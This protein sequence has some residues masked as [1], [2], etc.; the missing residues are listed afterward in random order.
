MDAMV[1]VNV[2]GPQGIIASHDVVTGK[3]AAL[4]IKVPQHGHFNIE[5]IDE[6]T[7]HAPQVIMTKRVG[8]NLVLVFEGDDENG[9][10]VILEDYYQNED[11]HLIGE[12]ENGQYY[13][14][15]PTTG[16][17]A[18]YP[19][20]LADG[21]SSEQV[22]GGEGS[23]L[24]DP[25]AD[26][27]HFAWLPW[28]IFGGGALGMAGAAIASNSHGH[29]H[30][31]EA[32]EITIAIHPASD[33]DKD[34]RPEFSGSSSSPNATVEITLPDGS[35]VTTTTD[36]NG[37][38]A[39]ESPNS[40]PN[41][42]II[43]TVTDSE[44]NSGSASGN[45]HDNTAP[46]VPIIN[47]N[48]DDQLAGTAEPGSTITVTDPATGEATTT[49][50]DDKGNWSI[51]PNP[52][53]EGDS[54]VTV[55]A[56]DPAGNVSPPLVIERPDVTLPD[57]ITSGLV[58]DS[59]GLNDDVAPIIGTIADGGVTNDTRPTYSGK[60]T[61]DIDHVNI[62][63]NGKLVGS[64]VVDSDGNW[65]FT[66]KTSLAEGSTHE[67][68]A[69][70]VDRAGNEGPRISGT[71][72][73]GWSFTID[74][75]P[76]DNSSSGI[77]AGSIT[78]T[79]DREPVT[80][81]ITDGS[82]TNDTRPTYSGQAT[83]DIDH[84]NIYDGGTLLGSAAVDGDG[85]WR[86]TPDSD[87]AEGRHEFT[88]SAVDA[89]GNEG[90]QLS[91]TDDAGW[92][93]TLDATAPDNSTSGIVAGSITLTDDRE[94]VTGLITDGSATNDTRPTYSGQATADI[95][96]V[97]IY[98]GGT[99]LGSAAVDGDGHWRFTP[100]SDLAEGR[101]EFTV[102]AVDASGN[103]GP[104]LSGTDDAGWSF[105]LDAT[106]PDNST[107]G[108]V[109]GSITLTDDREPV[110]G[111]ITDGSATNDTRPTYSGQATADID[112][113]NIYDGGTLLGSAAVDGDG[114]WRFTPDSDLAEGRHE[115]T[116]SAV[117]ASG[118]EGP[119]LSGTDDAGWSFTLDAT[120]PDNSTSG[121]VAGSITLTDDREPVTGE[122]TDGSATNDTRPTY[123]GQATAD[124]DHVN[125]YD[126]GTLLGSAAVDGDGH[127]RFTPDSDLAE[128]RHEFT[129]SA[130]DASGNEG[131][132]LSGTDDAG[133]SF[134]LDATAPD[135]STSGIVAGSITLTDDREPVTGEITDGSATNDTR[136]TY[137]GQATADID[138]VNIYDGGTLLGSAAVDGDG[139]W[140]FTPDSDLAEGRHEF[141][142]SAV[143]ASGN[144]GPP[145]SGTDD[146]GWS[147][148]LDATAPD[149]STS[150][151][152]VGSITLT[153]DREPVT[154]EITDGSA[155]NDTR[156][157]YSGQATADIDHVN[158]YDGGT[159]LGSA[160]VDGDGH[161]RFTPDSDL[162]EGRHEFT[163]S[164]VD[165]SGN[166]GPPLSGTDDAGWSFTLDATAPD[167]STSGI[168]AGSITLTDDRE[169]VTGE[170][171]DGSATNDTRPTYSGQA[172]ADID[173]VNIY[174]GGTLLGSA[175]VDGDGHWRF[176]PDSDLAEGRHE[177]TVSAVD[178]SGNE[179]PPLS[180]TDDAGWSFTL[181]ATAP[182]NS[183]SGIVAGSITLTDD[184][185]PVTGEITD[186]S[187]TNDTR[188]TY[189][190]QATADIDH[191]NIYDGGTLL[192]SAAVD[193]DGHWRFTPDSD[194][195][196]GRHEFTVSAV[197][198]SGNEGP[199]LSG[200]DDAGWSFT[201]D[202]TAPDN[203]TSGIVAGSI[204][205]TD[206]R[207]PVTG[208]ITD[209]SA[210]N[211]T[212][213]TYS[214]QATA[215][216][217]HVNIYDGGTLL[218]SA[219]VDGDGHWR[220]TPDSDL[221]EG[222][223]EFTVSAVDTSG[224]EGPQ[225]SGTD[226][227]GWSF[228]LDATAPD[229]STSGIVAG[230]I[231]LTDDREP[232]TGEITDGSATND[233]R[234][235]YSGQATADIDHVNIYDGGTLLGSAAVDGDGHWR[236][237]PDSDLAEG[238]HEFT[239]SA[240]DASGN[241]G[242][243]L[244]GTDDAGW[245]FTLDAT[246]PDNSTSGIVAGSITLTDDREP[247]TG[248]ITDGSATNDTR[249]TY[250]GQATADIDH[251]NIYDGGTLLGSAA[252]DGD[253]HWRFTPDSDLAEGRHEFTVS[254]VD[255]SGNEGPPLSGTDDAGWSFTLDATA[256]DN[257]TSGIVVGSITLT[258]DREPVTGEIT[259]GSATNDTRPTYSGQ[260]TADI[261]HVNIYDGGTLLGSAAVDG[262]GHWRFTPDSDL[263]EGRHEFTVSAVDASGNEGPQLSGTDD[264]GWSFTLDA[265][266]P[267]NSTSG[268]VAGSITLTD[269]REPVTGEI[270]D[271]SATNDTRP[272]YSGQATADIDHVN[273]YDGGTLLGS[274]AVDGDGHWR[275]TPD[276][277]LAEGRHEF[278]VSAVDASGNE[279]PQLSGTDDAGWSFTLDA[280][281]PD[282]STSGIVAGSITL[283]DDR[284]PVTG[285]ITDGSATNDTRPT[286]SGQATADIDHVNIYD[287]GT[288]LG[289]AA[290]DGDGHWRFTPDSDL[291]EGRHEFTVSAV[292]A[293][294]NEGPQLSG[295]DDA[296]WSFTL[297]ATA[298]DNSTSGIV[299]GSITLTDDR[300]PVTGEITDGSATNDTR[301]TY[302]GQATADIDHVNIYD[303]GTLLGSAAV[304][305]DGHWRFTPDSDLA[306][307]R[308]EFTVSAVDASGNEGPQ[309]SG[310]DD[311]GWSF[312]L[313]ATAPDN[314]TSGIVAGSITLTDDR[315]PVT[316]EI[317]DGSATNDTRPTYSGQATADI[318][319]VNIYDGGT[320]LGSAAVDGDGHW[321][322]T[323]DSDLAEGRHEFTVSAVDASGNE[324]PQLSGTDDAGWSF[325]LDA[326]APDNSTSGIVAGSITLT[327]DREPVTG[328]IT[329]GSATNDTRPT[330][331]G[332][333]TADIDHV[334]IYDGGTLLGSAAVDGDGH[335]RFTPDS[336]LAEGRHEFTVS[337]VD[338]SGNEGPQ[339]S[340]TDDAGWSFTL[341]ATAPDN[342]TS[343]IVAG[344]ITLT[345][346]REPVTGEITD[347]SATNDTRPTYSG[348][349]TA[350]IDH[351]NIYDGGT[352]L[353]SA[354][355][356]GDGHWRFTPDS[357][358]AEGRHE[359][360]VS[361]VDASGNE[362]PPLSGTDDAGWSFTLDATAPDNSTSGIVAGSI[363]L[364][365]DREPVTGEITDG[366]A[367]NDTRPT[368]SGQATADI[369]H[370]NI[371]DG[372]TLLGSAAVDGDGHWRFTPDS[373][374]AEGRHEFTV[375]AVDASGNEGPPLSGTDDAG[376]S[377]TLDTTAPGADA[378]E[379]GSITL[380]DDVKPLTGPIADGGTTDDTQPTYA[381]KITSDG[382]AGGIDHVNIYDGSTLLGSTTVDQSTGAWS[383]T[384]EM[385]LASGNHTLTV[386][387]VDA[388]GNEG[389]KV[390]GT[391]D[392]GW[393]FNL[394]TSAPAQPSIESVIDD[395]TQGDE[396]DTGTLQKGQAT[397]DATLT[398][399]GSAA[400]G[401]IVKIWATDSDGNRVQV[402]E[403]TAD[404]NGRWSITTDELGA[405]GRYS[406]SAT[407]VNASG[408]SSAETGVFPVVLDTVAPDAAI[409]VLNDDQG[410]IQDPVVA[411]GVTDD[412][413]PTLSGTGEAG[414]TV[415]VYLDGDS[416]SAGSVVV[417]SDGSWILALPALE[418]GA[419]SYQTKVTDT[420]GNE[421]RSEAVNFTVDSSS[422]AITIDQAND[423]VGSI[424]DAVL[425]G[426]LTD[427]STPELQG[428][429][430][431]GA[432]VTVK[433]VDGKVLGTA[434]ADANGLWK[435]Q[436]DRVTDGE[437]SWTAEVINHAGNTAQAGITLTVDT[438]APAAPTIITMTDDVGTLQDIITSPGK[439]TDDPA[440][441]FAGT[442]ETG[443]TVTIYDG[444][445]VLGSVTADKDGNWSYTPTTN[446][447]DGEHHITATSTDEAGNDSAHS[448]VWD[449]TLDT[450]TSAPVITTNT[451]EEISGT[452]EPGATVTITDPSDG[453]ETSVTADEN[454]NWSIQPNPLE[455]GDSSASVVATDQAGNSNS[456]MVD[457]P[458]D[459]TPPDNKTSGIVA[460]SIT[461]TDDREPVTGEIT[462]GS[463]TNDTRPTYSG[464]A[465]ADIDHVNIYD[466]GTLLGSAAVDGDGRW[467][468]TP[469]SDLAEGRHEFTV[470]AV[471]TSGNEGPQLSGTDDAGWS[472]TLD[473]TA[474]DNST[475]GIVAGSITLTDDREPVTGEITDG[476]AT[477]DTRPTYSGQAT[478]DIDHVN[479]YDGGTLLGSAA[480]DGD[481]HWRF[482]PDSDL[483]E[484]RHEFTVSAVDASGNEGPPLSGTDDA[485]WSFTL[486]A[487]APDNST[488]G[489]VAGS[490][491]LT[492]DRE[493]VTGEITDG[494]ATNDTRPTYSGQATADIDHVNIYDGG[495][496]LGSAA[497]DGD[498]HWRFTP[499]SDLA[500]GRHEFTV[501]AVDASGNE[502][503]QLSGTDDA[504]WSFT[505]DAT[506]PDNST[507]GIVAGSIT[508][509]DDR[510]PVTGEITDG[511]A[512]NDTRPTYSGQA[513]ADIDH[514][515]IYDGGTLLGSA[516]VD[517][518]GHWR[519]TPDSDLAEGRHEFTVSA[520]DASGNEGPQLSGTDDESWNFSLLTSVPDQPLIDAVMD[521]HT[522]GEDADTGNL[523]KGLATNDATLTL[524]GSATAGMIVTIWAT[525]SDGNRVQVGEGTADNDG[526]WNIT[527][528]E[529]GAD[530]NYDLSATVV[531]AAGVSSVESERF[532]VVLD[533][534]A[535]DAV[536]AVLNDDRGDLQEPVTAGGVTDDRLLTLSGTGE[537]GATVS[538]YLDGSSTPAGS[539]VVNSDG[540]WTLALPELADGAHSYQTKI[541]DTA[542]NE[543]RAET[544]EFTIDSSS[545]AITIDQA[546]DNV[547]SITDAV[548]DGGLTDDSTPELQGITSA[549]AT[550]TVKDAEGTVL[551]TAIANADGLWTFQLDEVA[552]GEHSWTAE[553][554]NAAG[555][556]A[557][558][559]ITLT[560]DTTA[561]AAPV[562]TSLGDD[563]GSIQFVS[564]V[565]GNVTDDLTPTLTGTAEAGAIVTL[566]DSGTFLG[567]MV[568]DSDGKW[569]FTP[570]AD[571]TE[572][573]H[574]IT[575]TATDAAGNV[576][577]VSSTWDFILDVTGPNVGI[578]GNA[579][580]SLSGSSEPGAI[581][582]VIDAAGTKYTTTAD[583]NGS[584]ILV[585][586][587]IAAGESGTIYAIDP[588]GNQ[589]DPVA[590]Q[591]A[592]LGSYDLMNESVQ[593]NSTT[594]NDQANPTTT[595]LADGRIVVIWQST[596]AG[597]IGGLGAQTDVYMQLYE[598]DGV[599]KIGTEQQVNQ[600]TANNQDS[601]QVVALA[602]GGFLV[603]YESYN[604]GLD[605]GD[606]VIARRYGANGEA[607]TDEFLVNVTTSGN[608]NSPGAIALE[609][610]GYIITW[611]DQNKSIVQRS[612]DADNAPTSDEVVVASG[613]GMGASGGPEMATFTDEAHNGMYITVWNATSGPSDSSYTGVV[614]QI[615]DAEGKA[616][617]NAFQVNT[618][619]DAY[620][621][622]PDVITLA[623]GSFVVYWDT[624]DSGA[625]GSDVRAVH[626]TVD[627]ST[628]AVTVQ[629]SGDFI[630][631][632][633]SD[634]KQ[635]KPVGVALEDGGYLIIW[636]S[637]GGDGDGS[638]IY[639]QRY[640][641][642][643]NKVG[644]EFI[645]N[646][647]TA[648][649]QGTG[650]DSSDVT[651]ILD[652]TLMADGS[653]YVTW[654]S[655]N[656]DGSGMGVEGIVIDP[657]SSYYSESTVNTAITGDQTLSS[658]SA[659]PGGG[660]IVVWESTSGDGSGTCI[661]GQM[662]DAQGQP[663]GGEF[664]VNS[665]TSGDQLTPQVTVLANG[666]FEV[667]WSSG[668]YI[669]GQKFS[670]AY[671]SSG[672]ISG[673]VTSGTEYNINNGTDA[674]NQ[675]Y[676]EIATLNDGGYM[677]VW[678]ATVN[679]V[680]VV[681][682]RQYD[683]NGSP[684]TAQ[685]VLATT[686]LDGPWLLGTG[687]WNP[688]P[689]VTTL[690]DGTVA[691]A[692]T[693]KGDGYDITTL[694]Y[695]PET[696]TTSSLGV[697][698]QTTASNQASPVI[699]ALGN[700]N[701]VVTWDSDNNNGPDQTGYSVWGRI[702]DASGQAVTDEF[703]INTATSGDQHLPIVVS[704][705]DGSFVVV[706]VSGTDSA[707]GAD[708]YGIYAQYFDAS[709]HKVG[710]QMQI[711]QLSWGDQVEVDASFLEGGQLYVTWT[712]EGVGD[713]D[714][715]A[716]K[717]RVVDLVETLGL[718]QET[719][720][721][722]DP[723]IIDYQ[724]AATTD[725]DTL[726]PNVGISTNT[727]DKLG[728]QTEPGATVTVTDA[729]GKTYTAVADSSGVW[730]MEP[731]PLSV[732]EQGYITAADK[733][734]N[735]S[736]PILIKGTALDGY[737]LLDQSMQVNTTTE[738]DQAN[739]TTTR[740]ADGR[741]VVIWQST[742]GGTIGGLG[743]QIDVYMQ[744]Y[745]ADGVHKI[746]TEQQVNQRTA[747][748][749]DSP[750]V[751]ALADGG[752]LVVY[753][754][755]NG[756]L[757]SGD[758][759]IA[760]RYGANGEAATDEF[761][762]NVTTSGNQNS[763]GAIALEDGGYIITW[764]DQ[765]K[766]IVQRSYDADDAP[767]S[768]EVVVASGSGM[769]ASGGPEMATFTDEAHNGMYI[770]VWNAT[771][772]P[773]DS[774]YTGVVGQ[775][776]DAE[777]K[778]LGNAFQVNTTMDAY[779]NYPD[780]IT[781][782]DGSFV[783]Y[784]DTNDSG[785]NG[786]DVRAVH[787]TVDASTGAVTVQ[788]SGD[789]IVNTYSDGKQYKPVGVAL[790]DGGY[791]IIWGSDGGD[792][793]GSAIYAQRYDAS[794]NKV[795]R[796]FIVNTTTAG[797]QGTGGD[798]SD[799][800]HI[801]DA[802]LMADGSVYVTWQSDNVDGSGMGVEGIVVNPDAA[803]YSE[804]TVNTTTSGDQTNPTVVA[805]TTG[806]L[807]EVW[808]SA[809]GDGSGTSIKGQML[810]AQ[811]QPIG[812]EFTVN[813]T[814][815][816]NQLT[817]VVLAN[818][819]IEVIWTSPAS[820]NVNY[821]K[822]QQYTYTYDHDG[823]V[824]G[825]TAVGAEYNISS[826]VGAT[827][828]A[829]PEVTALADGG[830]M[831]VWEAVVNSEYTIYARQYNAEGSP[832][833]GE[834]AIAS[835][836]L[837][838]GL[839]GNSASW[840][841]Y[842][843]VTQLDNGDVAIAYA[844]HGT[845][846]DVS[847]VS[848]DTVTHTVSGA[849]VVN[850][851]LS[852]DQASASVS[853]LD[854]GNYVVT[855][856]SSDNSGPDQNGYGVWG[857]IY[858]ASGNAIT[859][860]FLINTVTAGDQQLAQ[861]V[862]RADGS[863]VAV[864]VSASDADAGVGTDGIYAQYFDADGNKVG[865]EFEINQ[866]TYGE[867][868]DVNATFMEG[869]Q[870][871]VTW[872][873]EGVGDGSGSGIKGRIVDLG[874]TLGLPDDGEG[875][876]SIEY[877]PAQ[878]YVNGTEGNDSLDARGAISV[879]AK[880]GNDTIFINSTNFT[881]ISGGE[882]HD[883]LVWDSGNNLELGS[884]SSKIS[885]IEVIH[886]GNNSAQTLVISASDILEMTR[887]NGDQSHTLYITGD[888]GNSNSNGAKDTV[889][890]DKSEWTNSS[891]QT[892]DGVTYDV[893][894]HNDD[895]TVKLMIQHGMNVL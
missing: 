674:S 422:V 396:V 478:A 148:T 331:S 134:T 627:A 413:S 885:A 437:H 172:T 452:A 837:T 334:N 118:N 575:A 219:A 485:G 48:D 495:T 463:A 43:V 122:I 392:D 528:D 574:S 796:E 35:R 264:A 853:A 6:Q 343:G 288:L 338:A 368:Y 676:P 335:W 317:T 537:V 601:P 604:G 819:N 498:G 650:G 168:V 503:P 50:A 805:L 500:E 37:N 444:D 770:T 730:S 589:G 563:V 876:T 566:Y 15:I 160:A 417:N 522:Q 98:D 640:D 681:Y 138:H 30:S 113:V 344:S 207:E 767:T 198:A 412:R 866:L 253:G 140:R 720:G 73:A 743:A 21:S 71:S 573:T 163:V 210:T 639:A 505:L 258:D 561:P 671:D 570:D 749:Q 517:G 16:D 369:D 511:S 669:K 74:S 825:L 504:G 543:T 603:V 711:N 65:S 870:L 653:V 794:D 435:Y 624:N 382:L 583:Q 301:P 782:A 401:M 9:S 616:L 655:D 395:R 768:D 418:D 179:G 357:D 196:E 776:F 10:D 476:S 685:T 675:G 693:T 699:T 139:H 886:M 36:E 469:D 842:P 250:S 858:G 801:L 409:A 424:T 120:A 697:V 477:N 643:D 39:I 114:H 87:L 571:L 420:A 851:T 180:G 533:T 97:N 225:L 166:E 28:I 76:P 373:D 224:N 275:F 873:D 698:N 828:Q 775:I 577:E 613:S 815:S 386:S 53:S 852:G 67:Y 106:A 281:A 18:D 608:Q 365:D 398:L 51:Q 182:D 2:R 747:N 462:D 529:L 104:Q 667:V 660:S 261:D 201:L 754:S 740:L 262:D 26:N 471:D 841:S 64:A 556:T 249:P 82:A 94:P 863:F 91:G 686:T 670:Y 765:N 716:I 856:D 499:D 859:S 615:F 125:I 304:D 457:G 695:N 835:T 721:N 545:V 702:Y 472:F 654:Q 204:T 216:I 831:V 150:G 467:R 158:I 547:G 598:A 879:D 458:A 259:D 494:S 630:V 468:F 812:G 27:Q 610:G 739:P 673:V 162:A 793:D 868:V 205:L 516:A 595:R 336:D 565:Q 83:A 802:T 170:I 820:G 20:A 877:Q 153:D 806:G 146:A 781:L 383:F 593:V 323:P 221:A 509:T 358:L 538:V 532:P 33:A 280:T 316:G 95:D 751:V 116:V 626:Y 17:V 78:L 602:D 11:I 761:L 536:I 227:A 69:A 230:S 606:G 408:I 312:T 753:E 194:L 632:T 599:H 771:S 189:S 371:Y 405:D 226:D 579:A 374:L 708:T 428:T 888:D 187:A 587:P 590:F 145:L 381:G 479:I 431:A 297:D 353:G 100:D 821:I 181:D 355:V 307:G 659:L 272:T 642:S 327:D 725:S 710:Q 268:I 407:A 678:Q 474:P 847:V 364:T 607:A 614:G 829:N 535:P 340:G 597:T 714:G 824:N 40:Q 704:R 195:A 260:A 836:G 644:R 310:T 486:D 641:A 47:A 889:N 484:G 773:S 455:T 652:A 22:L 265:T 101:H 238:R 300:E 732:G 541:T 214:G 813:S 890:I 621:N 633:Y 233:T 871:Y 370:V 450:V 130:V 388:A 827:G 319:H 774:S 320:L 206:D 869:G 501:S 779:Q 278:T 330:Y 54:N 411:G 447:V 137:S 77:V 23:S 426:G 352:L 434:I 156:P 763:P 656:V 215:D 811:G 62:Y 220:F 524:K 848:Y 406:L 546:N 151:I 588:T 359:F 384:P 103:E 291:A 878:Y 167:N 883:T 56:Q 439:V 637:D 141:T 63:D 351:V 855:W 109:A 880:E 760:R 389:P 490:I 356:D 85:H 736:S 461:L 764:Q 229:N 105:T 285:E 850:Q 68:T 727:G 481:G 623:D 854:N 502:G 89:S 143:D 42:T 738:S 645:V 731:N 830:Y 165:A 363:T 519:F 548:L 817:P 308:H 843:S 93:F 707:P 881:G 578:S 57:N 810:D 480:V 339:L 520:V 445:T 512:T 271:G 492:D 273:I 102:S 112:H 217:D 376:W 135:N 465:T 635:Y 658:V 666:D 197:D 526:R 367:T 296:G 41:G 75:L 518:D 322:F 306:E 282:N 263:A 8:D 799:V 251:V 826:G 432:S 600:R 329:D 734:G 108:I 110:T 380:N 244:S 433:D 185:E 393:D 211:D 360:T 894:V 157:T 164:A 592:A 612:Y 240:V 49:V 744:L 690:A 290:V 446:L 34:G 691:I 254:A 32:R 506:A 559:T 719:A 96:H 459:T 804:F 508:L 299:A 527:T 737:D 746:G 321:R 305:G 58:A 13:E 514:V 834:M 346:D 611:Q 682:G 544:V 177:F 402:G 72:D 186:G 564:P 706:F 726:P 269:D 453:S 213:P 136:P 295:T 784:W 347:G 798:S 212:R 552:D 171:T 188:P 298:P 61:A 769:G 701:Y 780:V 200:T 287:G 419:H 169:P 792:G 648:G 176:T 718:E 646:T 448:P 1:K 332:Q 286:Y 482:T 184:R 283:T 840:S 497:V 554:T 152:V 807:F 568:A 415:S 294:G 722:D 872:T 849:S 884:V 328:E 605:S 651:H 309:L 325:T 496:L 713:G 895:S 256:P 247:V 66:S 515:N 293:S 803:W 634:G 832:V 661:R 845:G 679:G 55:V 493:P 729:D 99:L 594:E 390:S 190:G 175:A 728:G 766:S 857:R 257:S 126:G 609:D 663:I 636:G 786:S 239:V 787:Y 255:A 378:F 385:A 839:L 791:L 488:S 111:E 274:A 647:T 742:S 292:D 29:G 662:L 891:S 429:T 778:A 59:L 703:I 38:W 107:S 629:G 569:K 755:Y 582:T 345:D 539:V 123:S 377:F 191:V 580:E 199:P 438:T 276:S 757:D 668:T 688:L 551:G 530:G 302:S 147:F 622:Y 341:D 808:V 696:H 60:A 149:N 460:G 451:T 584:W 449:F 218:G 677:V 80:G 52:I 279:G 800:T 591:G 867:Q 712:D 473:A 192:G 724:P 844:I 683:E 620:Q 436:L 144:E 750:Q 421:T 193:G 705:A 232:V 464:Q 222:R 303:G 397:N 534:V 809:S 596:S 553:I 631:N 121:I 507:S 550:V 318:D 772:G 202:A 723:T 756:G 717:G 833:T 684:V 142:V 715:S 567:S 748:N 354:A 243:Q 581:I 342:S 557:R 119:Q 762:V 560:V 625:N 237:T 440:P 892:E 267:D 404:E 228:T 846:Y 525:D 531:N 617:G 860:E 348:Q 649:N 475:S 387:A 558:D 790:E 680:W 79:D 400:E 491:T 5:L 513:T 425:N 242:P 483:A 203:S 427:D 466:G 816:G 24:A 350:D 399:N 414:A 887:D 88:V 4:V 510:E 12:A 585:P 236:F 410:D 777:G 875:V 375:S 277:D 44:G 127:W 209:G 657:D 442:A 115:F 178:A 521:D 443:S 337:A 441:T 246:A 470:S 234:P 814:T 882:G 266:A 284:E 270:T 372:G 311:A 618:T 735:E 174:D 783:V 692:Y 523:Q 208:E 416:T 361:A 289:S 758:G 665:T 349:A 315:E 733:S 235:T 549:G 689:S 3:N 487:T 131:P 874:E 572:G 46:E 362:G 324:G 818:G 454:G 700:G 7:G 562:I 619:M 326:T 117:D 672:N 252:V 893:Y 90:P 797:N 865:Q 155:T 862:S 628:G 664:T 788:G 540:N 586:N 394:L 45:Y 489:I 752:F 92:S 709:G 14:F 759:V 838:T 19:P 314:S 795:G 823:N 132:Q 313:D 128:G 133:W 129:V 456:T 785:A 555:N 576:S 861:V 423:N 638:A 161:W 70:A 741:I 822:A 241:E 542:G 84:V 694:L 231:T 86:F 687:D 173:H 333:A 31:D 81:E 183:T 154:G 223:H 391:D 245:S 248:E 864:F 745:E 124:I 366:S 25:A 379:T 159:L 403:G 789:F 430:I